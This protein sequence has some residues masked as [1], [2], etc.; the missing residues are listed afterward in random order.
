[1]SEILLFTERHPI[2]SVII[3]LIVLDGTAKIIGAARRGW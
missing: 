1:M 3:L 2:L